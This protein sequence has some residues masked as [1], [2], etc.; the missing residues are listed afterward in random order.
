MNF[1]SKIEEAQAFTLVKSI[2]GQRIRTE[3]LHRSDAKT[4]FAILL[5][6]NSRRTVCRLY[7]GPKK[8]FIGTINDRKVET[9]TQIRTVDDILKFSADL[10]YIVSNY[11][12]R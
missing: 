4:Y 3:R 2:L 12:S 11:E 9:R 1:I 10:M 5:D 8:K 6:N 7:L